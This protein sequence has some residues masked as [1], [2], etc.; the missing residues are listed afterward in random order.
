MLKLCWN[1]LFN[2]SG[3][4]STE[5]PVGSLL[6]QPDLRIRNLLDDP[7]LRCSMGLDRA[8]V[9]ASVEVADRPQPRFDRRRLLDEAAA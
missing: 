3:A 8:V 2:G 1:R 4:D 6:D 5:A 7:R 9:E